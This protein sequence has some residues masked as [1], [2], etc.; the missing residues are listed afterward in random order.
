MLFS[1]MRIVSCLWVKNPHQ[2]L[3]RRNLAGVCLL[4]HYFFV[5]I[6][7]IFHR[8]SSAGFL[9]YILLFWGE[10]VQFLQLVVSRL[11]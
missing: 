10:K 6:Q 2:C 3:H 1:L 7:V 8:L 11:R 9:N 4:Q 5:E